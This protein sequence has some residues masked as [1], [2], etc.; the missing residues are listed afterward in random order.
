MYLRKKR[1][2]YL[3]ELSNRQG[4][5]R[6]LL[7]YLEYRFDTTEKSGAFRIINA[8]SLNVVDTGITSIIC[9]YALSRS[10]NIRTFYSQMSIFKLCMIFT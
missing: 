4:Y 2:I 6:N 1:E 3:Y 8:S 10:M 7:Y 5:L 9:K